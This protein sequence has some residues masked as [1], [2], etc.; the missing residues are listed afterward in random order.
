MIFPTEPK[1]ILAKNI[2]TKNPEI[3]LKSKSIG[4][5]NT[6]KLVTKRNLK[7]VLERQ[8]KLKIIFNKN[9]TVN[10]KQ[11]NM[12]GYINICSDKANATLD[13]SQSE[14]AKCRQESK[15]QA[16]KETI[17]K[18]RQFGLSDEQIA[19]ALNLSLEVVKQ[20]NDE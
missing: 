13:N 5:P 12:I 4:N 16:N 20:V 1:P 2:A 7:S 17:D 6:K 8:R 11:N 3:P 19:R 15:N 14:Q 10:D 18:L 9:T